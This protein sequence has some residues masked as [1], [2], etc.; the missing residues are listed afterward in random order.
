MGHL[1]QGRFKAI[2]VDGDAYLL[3]VAH[4]VVLN[5]VRGRMVKAPAKWRWSSYRAT[6]GMESTPPWLKVDDLPAMF[7][8]SRRQAQARYA[9]FVVEGIKVPS[10]WMGLK[11]QVFL[12]VDAFVQR[13]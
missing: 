9:Q 10:P 3:E 6:G 13:M 7:G 2:L 5:P 12:G 4:Y 11:A 8:R 1:F